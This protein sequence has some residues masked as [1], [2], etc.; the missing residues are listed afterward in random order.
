MTMSPVMMLLLDATV[1]WDVP[2]IC[3]IT[4][5]DDALAVVA[6]NASVRAVTIASFTCVISILLF[7]L[8]GE[9][10]TR[11]APPLRLQ[12]FARIDPAS[13]TPASSGSYEL[14]RAGANAPM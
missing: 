14:D 1:V 11:C 2:D 7:D 4:S 8:E 3:Q 9:R 13:G 10:G 12:T 6:P 5:T